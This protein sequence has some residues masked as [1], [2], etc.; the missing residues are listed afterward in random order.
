[1]RS[2]MCDQW[3]ITFVCCMIGSRTQHMRVTLSLQLRNSDHFYKGRKKVHSNK[4]LCKMD[5]ILPHNRC[6]LCEYVSRWKRIFIF[7]WTY[8]VCH[9]PVA[10]LYL[11]AAHVANISQVPKL[12]LF[13]LSFF[14]FFYSCTQFELFRLNAEETAYSSIVSYW[15]NK[16][17]RQHSPLFHLQLAS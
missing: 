6:W 5:S 16:A 17:S 9:R 14:F 3:R 11:R 15:G 8:T 7:H 1:M 4:H 2:F 13:S 12:Q 10:L